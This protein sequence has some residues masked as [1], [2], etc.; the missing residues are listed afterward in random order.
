MCLEEGGGLE[1]VLPGSGQMSYL[2]KGR[3][4]LRTGGK[5]KLYRLTTKWASSK[6]VFKDFPNN[7][8]ASSTDCFKL[9]PS[10]KKLILWICLQNLSSIFFKVLL[11]HFN[12]SLRGIQIHVCFYTANEKPEVVA[13]RCSVKKVFL[14]ISQNSQENTC[15]RVSF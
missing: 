2:V 15:D 13:R 9:I 1:I 8:R 11:F 10:H 7:L 5:G 3:V 4:C 6:T 12:K 14:N